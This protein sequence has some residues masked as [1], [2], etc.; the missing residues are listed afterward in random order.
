[1]KVHLGLRCSLSPAFS[2]IAFARKVQSERRVIWPNSFIPFSLFPLSE[3]RFLSKSSLVYWA[4]W[5]NPAEGRLVSMPACLRVIYA[6]LQENLRPVKPSSPLFFA[7]VVKACV[8]CFCS[9]QINLQGKKTL[10]DRSTDCICWSVD[11][12]WAEGEENMVQC[13]LTIESDCLVGKKI[14]G[15]SKVDMQNVYFLCEHHKLI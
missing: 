13:W 11:V 10:H 2:G 5:F 4:L 3:S 1:M 8:K 6:I 14:I 9:G 12:R 7:S 15:W